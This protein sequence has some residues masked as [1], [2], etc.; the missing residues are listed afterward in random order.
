MT[1]ISTTAPMNNII[2]GSNKLT[3]TEI[4][5]S[6]SRSREVADFSNIASSLPLDSPLATICIKRG[7]NNLLRASERLNDAPCC[8]SSAVTSS[9][10]RSTLFV[11][12]WELDF[13]ADING[14]P[15][16]I[17]IDIVRAILEVSK[18]VDKRLLGGNR[19]INR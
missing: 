3:T 6:D 9:A 18:L 4:L 13:N 7:G 5:A 17:K 2:K 10:F 8:T 11:T 16:P 14:T 19:K 1:I 12:T 15:L